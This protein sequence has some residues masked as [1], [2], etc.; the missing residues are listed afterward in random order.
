ML[1]AEFVFN[2]GETYAFKPTLELAQRDFYNILKL[3]E[4]DIELLLFH[5]GMIELISYWKTTC[6][7]RV[8]VKPSKLSEDQISWWKKL[9]F[10]GLGEFFYLN[11]I[12]A[13]ADEF[14]QI[15]SYGKP[16]E[17]L[18]PGILGTGTLVPVGGGKDS[19]VTP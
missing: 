7:P 13:E 15:E 10:Q 16:F 6:S 17:R 3:S 4:S 8:V 1:K 5:I 9:Y 14:M 19:V 2:I 11:G 12:D 18:D